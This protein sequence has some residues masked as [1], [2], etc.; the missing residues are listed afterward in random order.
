MALPNHLVLVRH[1]YSEGNAVKHEGGDED[2]AYYSEPFYERPGRDWRLMEQGVEEAHAA[3]KWIGEHILGAYPELQNRF[4]FMV[5]SPLTRTTETAA[6]LHLP[7]PDWRYDIRLRERDWGDIESM[8]LARYEKRYKENAARKARDPLYWRPP[9][10]ESIAQVGETR[11]RSMLGTLHDQRNKKGE[12]FESAIFSTHGEW[13][14]ASHLILERM[15]HRDW[16]LAKSDVNRKIKNAQVTH[17]TRLNPET[18]EQANTLAWVR[19]VCPWETPDSPG[20]WRYIEPKRYDNDEL[21][22]AARAVPPLDMPGSQK[23]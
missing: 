6:H 20:E 13:I 17:F 4:D 9:G 10:G 12:A 11:F 18:G 21:L 14:W 5:S 22:E 23:I 19:S 15:G 1:G 7:N 3:G 2:P 8:S 16:D